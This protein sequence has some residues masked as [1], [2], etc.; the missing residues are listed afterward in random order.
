MCGGDGNIPAAISCKG[1]VCTLAI[2]NIILAIL[3]LA[4]TEFSA[5]AWMNLCSNAVYR[6]GLGMG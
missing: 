3:G 5:M 4:F 6:G 1:C 2:C